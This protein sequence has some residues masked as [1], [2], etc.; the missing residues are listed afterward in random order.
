LGGFC[1]PGGS[2]VEGRFSVGSRGAGEVAPLGDVS[3]VCWVVERGVGEVKV[4]KCLSAFSE[5]PL[6]TILHIIY[7]VE[8]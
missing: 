2:V 6:L 3:I 5:D 8:V 1:G 4:E 7:S